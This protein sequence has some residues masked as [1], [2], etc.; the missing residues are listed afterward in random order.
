MSIGSILNTFMGGVS[1]LSLPSTITTVR[2]LSGMSLTNVDFSKCTLMTTLES[3]G[4]TRIEHLDLSNTGLYSLSINSHPYLQ[5]INLPGTLR[6]SSVTNIRDC[7]MLR[8]I[9]FSK[10]PA[11]TPAKISV[12][13]NYSLERLIT[14]RTPSFS[15]YTLSSNILGNCA[16]LR[17]VYLSPGCTGFGSYF[18]ASGSSSFLYRVTVDC[19]DFTAVPTIGSSVSTSNFLKSNIHV[20]SCLYSDWST[21]ANW[22][23]Y[24]NRGDLTFVS[25]PMLNITYTT[26]ASDVSI[27]VTDSEDN[28]MV[29]YGDAGTYSL[30][31]SLD[32]GTYTVTAE[33]TGYV[34]HD[35]TVTITNADVALSIELESE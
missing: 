28:V 9:D 19:K 34:S 29:A 31:Y 11:L 4:G 6:S 16:N 12:G 25:V 18:L 7:S 8:E 17:Y 15:S 3:F 30:R 21:S 35:Y 23:V 5:D 33:A 32:P 1:S 22:L 20:P 27:T 24:V 13:S 26:P 2:N 10:S 14:T